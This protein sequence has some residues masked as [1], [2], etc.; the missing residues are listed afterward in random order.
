MKRITSLVLVL[1]MICLA[2]VSCSDEIGEDLQGYY[3]RGLSS[4]K[5]EVIYELD[6]YI[7]VDYTAEEL[8]TPEVESAYNTV[9]ARINEYI[10]SKYYA[11]LY[12]HF[13][14]RANYKTVVTEA[15]HPGYI[16]EDTNGDGV[17]DGKDRVAQADIVLINS[18]SL[19]NALVDEEDASNTM[20]LPV[21]SQ[22]ATNTF[23][24]LNADIA[25]T[26]WEASKQTV[27]PY[28]ENGEV[29]DETLEFTYI[30]PNNRVIGHYEYLLID[31]EAALSNNFSENYFNNEAYCPT[32]GTFYNNGNVT[33]KVVVGDE[34]PID[35]FVPAG[36]SYD[37]AEAYIMSEAGIEEG[38][39]F[40]TCCINPECSG[41]FYSYVTLDFSSGSSSTVTNLIG[42][43]GEQNV[44]KRFAGMYEDKALLENGQH[45]EYPGRK[46]IVKTLYYPQV[47]K[48]Y[49]CESAFG[50]VR[51]NEHAARSMQIVYRINS[52]VTLRNLLLYGVENIHYTKDANGVVT[53]IPTSMYKMRIEYTGNIFLAYPCT[54]PIW[55]SEPWTNESKI[56][57]QIQNSESKVIN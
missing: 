30:I 41:W 9:Q 1:V 44:I 50:I 55:N 2:L 3:D 20:L 38:T 13:V 29:T 56:Y 53:K 43:I 26:L 6:M 11:K 46:F 42:T 19:Y 48:S 12:I 7:P 52:D 39:T 31:R 35:V 4:T 14:P 24:T 15:V 8:K 49:A 34:E 40:G 10:E 25:K 32:C 17:K 54:D 27:G 21:D 16:Y 28:D 47:T 45:P 51:D 37:D 33:I 23:G 18:Y 22:L 36:T 5:S 57:G